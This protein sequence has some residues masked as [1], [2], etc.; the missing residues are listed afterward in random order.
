MFLSSNV[1][2]GSAT[3]GIKGIVYCRFVVGNAFLFDLYA[4]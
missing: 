2:I 3:V 4:R 1:N